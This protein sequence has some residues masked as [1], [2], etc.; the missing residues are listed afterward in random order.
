MLHR[1][2]SFPRRPFPPVFSN[3]LD[4]TALFPKPRRIGHGF[5][6]ALFHPSAAFHDPDI[7]HGCLMTETSGMHHAGKGPADR[8]GRVRV[9]IRMLI[10]AGKRKEA[11]SILYAMITRIRLKEGCLRSG[12]YQDAMGGKTLLFE[13]IWADENH[14]RKHLR[15]DEFRNVLLVVE[16][17]SEPPEI[18]FDRIDHSSGVGT[19]Q[20]LE[21]RTNAVAGP[22]GSSA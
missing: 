7:K 4:R 12:L 14:F 16:M 19:L 21:G 3:E 17:A 22:N 8:A 2:F 9:A 10:P 6:T 15:S 20:E 18:H 5:R 13:E 11:R 1:R